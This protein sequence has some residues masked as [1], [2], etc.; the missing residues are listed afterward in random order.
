MKLKIIQR[1]EGELN[2]PLIYLGVVGTCILGIYLL[3]LVNKIPPFPCVF[4]TLTGYPCPTCGAT[5]VLRGFF[6]FDIVSAFS[7]NPLLF[8]AGIVFITWTFYGF[9]MFLSGK[10]IEIILSDRVKCL[11]RWGIILLFFL[12]WLYLIIAGI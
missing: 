7:W 8:L 4:K 3:Y 5:R 2:L 11:L 12:N 6:Q 9:Y 1:R 10:K